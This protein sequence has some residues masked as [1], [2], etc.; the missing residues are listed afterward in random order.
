[1]R[2]LADYLQNALEM[3][4]KNGAILDAVLEALDVEQHALG[5]LFVLVAKFN[6]MTVSDN[7]LLFWCTYFEFKMY[8]Y[9]STQTIPNDAAILARQMAELVHTIPAEHVRLVP[10]TCTYRFT[11]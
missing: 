8:L 10:Q 6:T 9:F 1:M 5:I 3:L 11:V 7:L 4:E 2:D